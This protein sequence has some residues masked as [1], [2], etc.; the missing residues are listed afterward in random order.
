MTNPPIGKIDFHI[1]SYASNVTSYY[2]AN[3][4]ALP[5]SFSDPVATYHV[6]KARGMSLVT[7]T[8][9]NSIDG[10]REM[11]DAGF[12]DVFISSELTTTFPEDGCNIHVT[13]ANVTEAQFAEL[14]QLRGNVYDLVARLDEL[15]A[16]EAGQ[17]NGNKIAYFMTHPLMSAQNRPAGREG[18]LRLEHIE[19][20][21]LLCNC[22]EVR[23]GTRSESINDLT[24]RMVES[25]DRPMI[26]RLAN[27]HGIAPKG[28]TPWLKGMVGG[29]D[30]HSGINQGRTWTEFRYDGARPTANDLIESIRRRET[31]AVGAH[32]GPVTLGNAVLK[33]LYDGQMSGGA[34]SGGPKTFKMGASVSMLLQ[35]AFDPKSASVKDRLLVRLRWLQ[36]KAAVKLAARRGSQVSFEQML[37]QQAYALLGDAKFRRELD[38]VTETDDKIFSV[39]SNVL[40]RMF[41]SYVESLRR[42]SSLDVVRTIKEVVA[43]VTS[44]VFVSLPYFVCY[45][46]Q[47]AEKGLVNKVRETFNVPRREKLVLVTDTLFD[48][49]GVAKT[50]WKI[51]REARDRD[52]DF[53]VVACLSPAEQAKYCD[54]PE[55]QTLLAE[56]H[57][58]I[59]DS[60]VNL[61]VPEY[62]DLQ[63]R[64]P[65]LLELMQF[66]QDQG[67]TKVQISTPGTVGATG[68]IAAK[69]LQLETSST[70]HTNFPEYVERYTKDIALEAI[71]WQAAVMF[72]RW[73]DE[74]VVPSH[75]VGRLLRDR[76][77]RDQD[78]LVLDR[79]VDPDKFHPQHRRIGY[80]SKFGIDNEAELVKFVY[81][82]RLGVEKDLATLAQAYRE[83]HS[84][85]ENAHLILVGG[86]PYRAE[87]EGMLAGVPVTF[88]G[89]LSGAELSTALASADVKVFPSTTDTWGN[90]PLEAQA[91]GLPV[92][93]T[94]QGGPQELVDVG[95]TGL[96]AKG[97]VAESL[98]SAMEVLLD[99]AKREHMGRAARRFVEEH[100][101]D[102]PFSA[103]L[104]ANAYRQR[105]GAGWLAPRA[106]SVA[107]PATVRPGS[108]RIEEA[109]A[110]LLG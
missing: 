35:L 9:H 3:K 60:I 98:R 79:W 52:L 12:E 10:V 57:L 108:P 48:V 94:D 59:F 34:A 54:D 76:G 55:V 25:L 43:M 92:I 90:A 77:L 80:W 89:F 7:L 85:H 33:L 30:D 19:R 75:W 16:A 56:G 102:A 66:L 6:L 87:L 50:V 83:L 46:Q 44:N 69:I 24:L 40:N 29:S 38:A 49:N 107:A 1:H 14:D 47:H 74:L 72:Y 82:G 70:F 68:L 23:N 22:I 36:N 93:V 8:D 5:E 95:V 104:D 53:L 71:A 97:G 101:I 86:G 63:A 41:A 62:E 65:P 18:S 31:R 45:S 105:G 67:A 99:R 27:Q 28:D 51:A 100:Q 84:K 26:E 37:T 32:G 61:G 109:Y 13:V 39:I 88:T 91:S 64:F 17:P 81:V 15:I 110:D 78:M 11:L 21:L 96:C 73:V 58:K 42:A 103:I 4:F 106:A 2:A 20:A